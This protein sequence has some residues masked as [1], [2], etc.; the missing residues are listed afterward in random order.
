[1]TITEAAI[2]SGSTNIA[3]MRMNRTMMSEWELENRFS[4]DETKSLVGGKAI[5]A[6]LEPIES[7]NLSSREIKPANREI[8]SRTINPL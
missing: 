6:V 8:F 5:R 7:S 4:R 1:M 3:T 2:T